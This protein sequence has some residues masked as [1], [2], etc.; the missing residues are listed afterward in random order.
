MFASPI[1][2]NPMSANPMFA[3][4]QHGRHR[5]GSQLSAT[6]LGRIAVNGSHRS[7]A[8]GW[9]WLLL[10]FCLGMT[11]DA[12]ALRCGNYLIAEGDSTLKLTRYC[13]EPVD[14][15]K[16]QERRAVQVYD[17]GVG[18]YVTE[19]ESLPYEIW[20]YNFGPQRFMMRIT[21]RDGVITGM[22]SAGYG[23]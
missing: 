21:V 10:A 12:W 15:E 17:H 1:S 4:H 22:E 14:V 7:S 19:Y 16:R 2:A 20:T 3:N 6:T 23:Y 5:V 13:G 18:G 8:R 11:A 9:S